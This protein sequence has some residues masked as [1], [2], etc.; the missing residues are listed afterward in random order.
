[1]VTSEMMSESFV[2]QQRLLLFCNVIKP[3]SR[4]K[5]TDVE[6]VEAVHAGAERVRGR[7]LG[8][9]ASGPLSPSQRSAAETSHRGTRFDSATEASL[10]A[11]KGEAVEFEVLA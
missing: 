3:T 8:S 5:A 7:R 10:S 11:G 4:P 2:A 6:L 9:R 1:M